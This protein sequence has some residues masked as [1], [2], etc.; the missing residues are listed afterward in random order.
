[1]RTLGTLDFE[2]TGVNPAEC[3]PVSVAFNLVRWSGEVSERQ[4]LVEVI[5]CGVEVPEGAAAIHGLTTEKV[6]ELGKAPADVIPAILHQLAVCRDYNVP[7]VIYNAPFDWTLIHHEADRLGYQ[8]PGCWIIDPLVLDRHLD[9]WR[10]G[11]RTLAAVCAARN[12]PMGDAHNAEADSLSAVRLAFAMLN[13]EPALDGIS[14]ERLHGLQVSAYREWRDGFAAYLRHQ[15]K[16]DPE[17]E[18]REWPGGLTVKAA[19]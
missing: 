13:T 5:N 3:R 16:P 10:K 18:T 19:A 1:M 11:K 6:R 12:V 2:T 4:R 8:V 9:K 7:L 14:P 17:L 15:G